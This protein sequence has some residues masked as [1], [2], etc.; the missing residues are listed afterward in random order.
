MANISSNDSM[1]YNALDNFF[2]DFNEHGETLFRWLDEYDATGI[3]FTKPGNKL[4][5]SGMVKKQVCDA[6]E[7]VFKV[8]AH[9]TRNQASPFYSSFYMD[10]LHHFDQKKWQLY[11]DRSV[12][13]RKMCQSP[14]PSLPVTVSVNGFPQNTVGEVWKIIMGVKNLLPYIFLAEY[15]EN[16]AGLPLPPMPPVH[17]EG[18]TAVT[19]DS[20]Q[21]LVA[22]QY[23]QQLYTYGHDELPEWMKAFLSTLR[24][25]PLPPLFTVDD[26][27]LSIPRE[28]STQLQRVYDGL[29]QWAAVSDSNKLMKDN[30]VTLSSHLSE[31]RSAMTYFEGID[32]PYLPQCNTDAITTLEY[33][34]NPDLPVRKSDREVHKPNKKMFSAK[35]K[36]DRM[37][38]VIQTLDV[39]Q[40]HYTPYFPS[41]VLHK[42]AAL[43]RK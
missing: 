22:S 5:R 9:Y 28:T 12:A 26:S 7:A 14:L 1:I 4:M 21:Q 13:V 37:K 31:V 17:K 40:E 2:P 35:K 16:L 38:Q 3:D 15:W 41:L 36:E 25:S 11:M 33:F 23:I 10:E 27:P 39:L 18:L 24:A 30:I 20:H 34:R 42:A 29:N 43:S 8:M 19:E 6:I 32:D